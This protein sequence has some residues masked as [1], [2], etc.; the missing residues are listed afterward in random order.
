MQR[1]PS[2]VEAARAL[3]PDQP[4]A[5]LRP[6]AAT[7]AARFFATGFQGQ[8]YYAV[9]ANPDPVIIEAIRA[10]GVDHFDVASLAEVEQIAAAAPG[11]AMAFMHP[12]KARGAIRRAYFD[13]GI[14]DFALDSPAELAKIREATDGATDLGLFV[15]VAVDNTGAQVGLSGKFGVRGKKAV[16]LVRQARIHAARLGLCFHVGSQAMHPDAYARALRAL[17]QIILKARVVV[18]VIDVGGGFP[19]RYP[20][21]DPPPLDAY[22]Q[23]IERVVEEELSITWTCDLWCEPGR[24][25]AAEAGTVLA[26]V[27]L[28]KGKRLYLNEGTYGALFD[29]GAFGFVYPARRIRVDR[30]E[31]AAVSMAPFTLYGPT[32]DAIDAMPGPFWLPADVD[33]GDYIEFDMLGAYGATF[34]TGFNGFGIA[35]RVIVEDEPT[36]SQYTPAGEPAPAIRPAALHV[37]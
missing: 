13:Y 18:D 16:K 19:A 15:R 5:C 1:F 17:Q 4:L 32:C 23:A 6:H 34:R 26:R 24:A 7:R 28:R 3:R 36:L 27:E 37:L 30:P 33:E 22:F 11:A 20:H 31:N 9:K 25:L 2:A 8:S 12:I 29:A 21:L 10:G 14:R 35:E